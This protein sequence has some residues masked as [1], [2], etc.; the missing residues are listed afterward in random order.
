MSRIKLVSAVF[1]IILIISSCS[2][3]PGKVDTRTLEIKNKAAEYQKDGIT[4]YNAGRYSQA[5]DLFDL[6]YNLN[7]S[8][9]NE[10][11]IVITLNSIGKTK[12]AESEYDNAL[13]L[14]HSALLIAERL[15]DDLLILRTIGNL[16]DYY[17]KIGEV[18]SAYEL[19]ISK[20]GTIDS[21][22]NEESAYLAHSLSLIFRKKGQYDEALIYL[23]QS[24]KYNLKE[25]AYRALAADYYMLASIN[26]LQSNYLEARTYAEEALKY[27]KM[28]EYP[29][30]IAADLLALSIISEKM[31]N[32]EDSEVFKK[33]ADTVLNAIGSINK[34]ENEQS[35][36][37]NDQTQ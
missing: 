30:G 26:S 28:I 17:I 29:Q 23:N 21:I 9:D 6:A 18:D 4:Q 27:D 20:F 16:G 10:K 1:F 35:E 33:R 19:L 12:L 3:L 14:F 32:H 5:L 22:K 36:P 7:A 11:G 37:E 31:G 2:T 13:N 34:I 25:D 8:V 15:E 24:L